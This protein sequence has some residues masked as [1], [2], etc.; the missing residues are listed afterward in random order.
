MQKE[1]DNGDDDNLKKIYAF[2]S[3]MSG[4]KESSRRDFGDSLK[5]TNW[6]LDSRE[7]CHMAPHVE[8]FILVSIEDTDNYIE[9]ANGHHITAKQK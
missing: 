4:N 8:Y 9:V 2:M 5:L 3:Q 6:S 1:Y 7:T